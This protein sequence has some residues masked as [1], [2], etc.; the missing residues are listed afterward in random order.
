MEIKRAHDRE[1]VPVDMEGCSGVK[2]ARLFVH[3]GDKNWPKV[4]QFRLEPDGHTANHRHGW[5]HQILV[6]RGI[7]TLEWEGENRDLHGGDAVFIE[8]GERHQFRNTNH[9]RVH[10]YCMIPPDADA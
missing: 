1:F 6:E 7:L 2:I 9:Y 3:E 10:F 5:T 4:R 8:A